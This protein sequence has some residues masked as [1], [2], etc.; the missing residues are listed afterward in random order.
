[1]NRKHTR[2]MSFSH[3]TAEATVL[4]NRCYGA[5]IGTTLA[6]LLSSPGPVSAAGIPATCSYPDSCHAVSPPS[7]PGPSPAHTAG[8]VVEGAGDEACNGKYLPVLHPG[9]DKGAPIY[10][11]DMDHQI[12]RYRG[13]WHIAHEGVVVFY[14]PPAS[15]YWAKEPPLSG[16]R[17]F[18]NRTATPPMPTLS[19]IR[20]DS[21]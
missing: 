11:K 14:D 18:P 16:W 15:S 9:A 2:S 7:P 10:W 3:E 5:A 19:L 8:Y 1:M 4:E 13:T 20:E 17:Q 6:G 21:T 12:Y